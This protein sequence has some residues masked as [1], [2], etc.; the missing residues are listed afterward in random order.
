MDEPVLLQR[1]CGDV[2]E[3]GDDV[4]GSKALGAGTLHKRHRFVRDA[5]DG[6]GA[7]L[8]RRGRNVGE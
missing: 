2:V 4:V 3:G 1:Y 7:S 5:G 8:D 6:P